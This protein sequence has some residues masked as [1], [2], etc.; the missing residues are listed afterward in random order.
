[1]SRAM[2]LPRSGEAA[3]A[4]IMGFMRRLLLSRFDSIRAVC[5]SV[6]SSDEQFSSCRSLGLAAFVAFACPQDML[7]ALPHRSSP[8]D[9][10][11]DGEY[12]MLSL[13]KHDAREW[14]SSS[15]FYQMLRAKASN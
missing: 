4:V 2:P 12:F 3:K 8:F 7:A 5:V 6:N 13:S 11:R 15:T 14:P 10:L 1:M 9:R